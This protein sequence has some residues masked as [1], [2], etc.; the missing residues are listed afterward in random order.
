MCKGSDFVVIEQ[1]NLE[2][3]Q[4]V[5]NLT[6]YLSSVLQKACNV[7]EAEFSG[8]PCLICEIFNI[9]TTLC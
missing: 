9:I 8:S 3:N 1:S 6:I 5:Q 2:F 7:Y 4:I